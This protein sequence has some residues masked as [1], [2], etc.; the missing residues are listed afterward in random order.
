MIVKPSYYNK[1]RCIA[2]ECRDNCCIGWEIGI[3]RETDQYYRSV[4]G[5]F[6]ERLR[7]GICRD[8]DAHFRLE[9][10]RCVFLNSDNLCDIISELGEEGLCGICREHP[11]F[12]E[13]Y[14]DIPGMFNITETGLGLCC[15]EAARLLLERPEPISFMTE[16]ETQE[17]K[18]QGR[19]IL[20]EL[21]RWEQNFWK[22]EAEGQR[23]EERHREEKGHKEEKQREEEHREEKGHRE[24]EG[25]REAKG[26]IEQGAQRRE[27]T[28]REREE[29]SGGKEEEKRYLLAFFYARKQAVH[30]LQDRQRSLPERLR[31]FLEM[32]RELQVCLDTADEGPGGMGETAE[33]LI[34]A[35][36]RYGADKRERARR[37]GRGSEDYRRDRNREPG[38][39]SREVLEILLTLEPIRPSWPERLRRMDQ[40]AGELLGLIP[41]FDRENGEKDYEYEH[42]LVYFVYRYFCKAAFDGEIL[43]RAGFAV[44]GTEAVRLLDL[45]SFQ[46]AGGRSFPTGQREENAKEFSKEV[47]YSEENMEILSELFWE[48]EGFLTRLAELGERLWEE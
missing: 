29:D 47:E 35:A 38:I 21:E 4:K 6:G 16:W 5:P 43:S 1:F 2:S 10:E 15:E 30:L 39:L 13:W 8:G 34:E 20:G 41:A 36:Y 23:E 42:L 11:R 12:Y 31:L 17:E 46:R 19:R 26:Q 24:E 22:R 27:E 48:R 37:R 7:K 18:E 9:K 28:G 14:E 33:R 3:D 44:L 40:E 45:D 25:Q 32:A